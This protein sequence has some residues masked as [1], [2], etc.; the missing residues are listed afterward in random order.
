MN[1]TKKRYIAYML[2]LLLCFLFWRPMYASASMPAEQIP[3]GY[4]V[5]P[6]EKLELLKS[7][8]SKLAQKLAELQI[9]LEMLKTPSTEL[10]EQLAKA[11]K[12]LQLCKQELQSAKASLE[13]AKSL[14]RRTLTSLEI[15]EDKLEA[16]RKLQAR[17]EKRLKSQR[18]FW[19]FVAGIAALYGATK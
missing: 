5:V 16:E 1:P 7:N 15:L 2:P 17:T 6:T 12:E 19:V 14:Q 18:D 4:K 9:K 3:T 11:E 13:N 10:V 8:S